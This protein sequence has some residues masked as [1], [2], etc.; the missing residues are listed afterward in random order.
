MGQLEDRIV[1]VKERSSYSETLRVQILKT[2]QWLLELKT[3]SMKL[4]K[5]RKYKM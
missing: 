1:V 2:P 4:R 5:L 3:R